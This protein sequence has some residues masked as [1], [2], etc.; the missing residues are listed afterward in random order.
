MSDK[1]SAGYFK[2]ERD[3]HK[4]PLNNI[5]EYSYS[6]E[7]ALKQLNIKPESLS[8]TDSDDFEYSMGLDRV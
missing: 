7:A 1:K 6:Y 8:I 2:R 4:M 5:A 3:P